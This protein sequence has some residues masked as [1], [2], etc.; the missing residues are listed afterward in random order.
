MIFE[1]LKTSEY[2]ALA[3]LLVVRAGFFAISR[4][5]TPIL[6]HNVTAF[7]HTDLFLVHSFFCKNK[8]GS[9]GPPTES[10][11]IV[12]SAWSWSPYGGYSHAKS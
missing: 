9:A 4:C 7:K 8:I 1:L 3:Y 2:L 6:S 5:L 12:S 11:Q 10:L